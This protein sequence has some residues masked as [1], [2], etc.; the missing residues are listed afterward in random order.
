MGTR[1]IEKEMWAGAIDPV[2]GEILAWLTRTMMYEGAIAASGLTGG[3]DV[4][5]TVLPFILRGVK[6]LGIDS[7]MCPMERRRDAW[8]RLATDMKPA[9]LKA[10]TREIGLAGLPAAFA[11]LVKGEARGRYV[12]RLY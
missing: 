11:T 5:T 1:P 7:V 9:N 3:I 8:W 12:V 6:L 10:S 2:G 4:H